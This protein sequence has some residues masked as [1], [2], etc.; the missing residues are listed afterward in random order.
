VQHRG[1]KYRSQHERVS[2]EL[3]VEFVPQ[4][5]LVA[6]G[7]KEWRRFRISHHN[8][9]ITTD[10]SSVRKHIANQEQR[11][12]IM[13]LDETSTAAITASEYSNS[14]GGRADY[15][16]SALGGSSETGGSERGSS[17]SDNG[18]NAGDKK[19]R[20]DARKMRRIMAN[21]RSA[22]ESRERRKRLLED[23]QASVDKLAAENTEVAKANLAMRQELVRLLQ[24]SGLAAALTG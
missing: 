24:E 18:D 23:L 9:H 13:N 1:R 5:A 16:S 7:R 10:Y 20:S 6:F 14:S 11:V 3:P 8:Q 4:R 15:E 21:R 17:G 22:R 2:V 12:Y 19:K